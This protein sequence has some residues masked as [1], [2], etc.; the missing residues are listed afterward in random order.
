MF[1]DWAKY[2]GRRVKFVFDIV[3]ET[4]V[5]ILNFING[6]K[7]HALFIIMNLGLL[8]N[9]IVNLSKLWLDES[10]PDIAAFSDQ[11]QI[12]S[13]LVLLLRYVNTLKDVKRSI[14]LD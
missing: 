6:W 8:I 11:F 13:E 7:H 2:L 1:F 10:I 3:F 12:E 5:R 9:L 4:V 14:D